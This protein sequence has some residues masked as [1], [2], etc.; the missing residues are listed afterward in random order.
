MKHAFCVLTLTAM[1]IPLMAADLSMLATADAQ[2]PLQALEK[3]LQ[4]PGHT[5][6]VEFDTSPNITRRLA[7]GEMPDVLVAQTATV[8]RLVQEGRALGNT[9]A[10]IGK[11]GVGVAMGKGAARP[12]IS[13]AD[14]LKASLLKADAVV[15][16]QGA[17]GLLV[18]E[19][20][21]K[22]GVA[23]QIKSKVVQLPQGSD[24]MKR[25]GTGSGNQIG[26]TMVS[27]IKL[28]ESFGGKLVGPLPA[29]IQTYTPYE[30]VVLSSSK[31]PDAARAYVRA[32]VTPEARK[33]FTAAGWEF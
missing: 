23:D 18:E 8:D 11:I 4:Q 31:A 13:S 22:I 14:G 10:G 15:Y 2:G 25:L 30:A 24:V 1:A 6:K 20:L 5:I 19:M 16:S 26:F 32:I 12:D 9:R 21:K 7:A 29:A 27:E 33:V 17:S 28:G 3:Q